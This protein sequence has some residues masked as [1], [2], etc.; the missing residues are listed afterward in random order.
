MR[1]FNL[2]RG[3]LNAFAN[4]LGKRIALPLPHRAI[5]MTV[6]FLLK[7]TRLYRHICRVAFL[8]SGSFATMTI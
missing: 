7:A 3:L 5:H 6:Y 2:S 4:L 1:S 8:K